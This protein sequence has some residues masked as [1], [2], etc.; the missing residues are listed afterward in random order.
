MCRLQN[1]CGVINLVISA[2]CAVNGG[3]ALAAR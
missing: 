3:T 2:G 1:E